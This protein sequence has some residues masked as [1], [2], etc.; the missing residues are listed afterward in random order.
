M[1]AVAEQSDEHRMIGGSHERPGGPECRCGAGW[2][3]WNDRCARPA[4]A[5]PG[6]ADVNACDLR[7]REDFDFAWC[8]THDETFPLGATCSVRLGE[9]KTK[10]IA[11]RARGDFAVERTCLDLIALDER[12]RADRDR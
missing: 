11:A 10:A 3:W 8:E 6:S 5:A 7:T 2:D 4:P 12:V 1:T 9:L